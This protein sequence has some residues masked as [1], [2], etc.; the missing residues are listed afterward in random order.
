ME[1]ELTELVEMGEEERKVKTSSQ[2]PL[3]Q[4]KE[5]WLKI[6]DCPVPHTGPVILISGINCEIP[7]M[8][9]MGPLGQFSH[10]NP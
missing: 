5:F 4:R 10:I 2:R 6:D 7:E 8:E 3:L 9:P 1:E